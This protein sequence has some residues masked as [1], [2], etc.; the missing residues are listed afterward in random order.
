[1]KTFLQNL[2]G[3]KIVFVAVVIALM[4]VVLMAIFA[5]GDATGG[6]GHSHD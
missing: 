6:H 1:M 2:S 3:P 4:L 5:G